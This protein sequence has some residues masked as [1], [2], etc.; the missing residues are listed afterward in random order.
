MKFRNP[1]IP[2][3]GPMRRSLS[4]GG[5]DEGLANRF[6]V[7]LGSGKDSDT[8]QGAQINLHL[9]GLTVGPGLVALLLFTLFLGGGACT[10]PAK[11]SN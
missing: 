6:G 1:Y 9:G 5:G 8:D 11:P 3:L 2:G 10:D 4:R 7:D